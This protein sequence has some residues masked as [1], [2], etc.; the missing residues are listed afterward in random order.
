MRIYI[1]Y[2]SITY[3]RYIFVNVVTLERKSIVKVSYYFVYI[4]S[5]VDFGVKSNDNMQ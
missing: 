1:I 5:Q 3:S 2:T 4:R